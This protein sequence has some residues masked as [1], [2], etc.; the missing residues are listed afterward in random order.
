MSKSTALTVEEEEK[1]ELMVAAA[2]VGGEEKSG[3]EGK[4]AIDK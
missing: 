3:W 2:T 4:E 1:V